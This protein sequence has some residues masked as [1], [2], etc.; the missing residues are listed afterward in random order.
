[1][2]NESNYIT[3]RSFRSNGECTHAFFYQPIDDKGAPTSH[4][5]SGSV[6]YDR[7]EFFS[8]NSVIGSLH[9]S[10]KS[11][12]QRVLFMNERYSNFTN[13][14]TGHYCSLH[15]AAPNDISV[16]FLPGVVFDILTGPYIIRKEDI[17]TAWGRYKKYMLNRVSAEGQYK[18]VELAQDALYELDKFKRFGALIGRGTYKIEWTVRD[19]INSF[20][21]NK[22]VNGVRCESFNDYVK[23]VRERTERLSGLRR[24]KADMNGAVN[25][26]QRWQGYLT[27]LECDE[28]AKLVSERLSKV[29]ADNPGTRWST[30]RALANQLIKGY[31]DPSGSLM[32][33]NFHAVMSRVQDPNDC[34][35]DRW[36]HLFIEWDGDKKR[37][38]TTRYVSLEGE[39]ERM[40]GIMLHKVLGGTS[41]VGK[42]IGPYVVLAQDDERIQVGCHKFSMDEVRRFKTEYDMPREEHEAACASVR[43]AVRPICNELVEKIKELMSEEAIAARVQHVREAYAER[44]KE[45]E[46][47]VADYL[48]AGKEAKKKLAAEKRREKKAAAAKKTSARKKAA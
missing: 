31:D 2:K 46:A 22:A 16:F 8:Y 7:N 43:E 3:R 1:M 34:E 21:S 44:I 48:E 20:Y 39:S 4:G 37:V 38:R 6:S 24:I 42:H 28:L 23:R 41:I 5:R 13:T 32:R 19:K 47:K 27:I 11:K 40:V 25:N 29:C 36:D 30:C 10:P 35:Y 33:P 26:L 45:A 18:T 17:A 12:T 15:R 9:R 14:T